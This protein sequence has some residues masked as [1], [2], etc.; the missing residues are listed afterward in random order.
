MGDLERDTR[1]SGGEGRYAITLSRDWEIWGLNGGYM[2]AVA[3]RAAGMEAKIKR[4]VSIAC[5]FLGVP[6]P[7]PVDVEVRAVQ[8]GRRAESIHVLYS[9]DGRPIVQAIVRTAA[10]APGVDHNFL[11]MPE[12]PH[13]S[14]LKSFLDIWT[15]PVEEVPFWNNLDSRIVY[16]ERINDE[17][18]PCPANIVEWYSF[19]PTHTFDDPFVDAARSVIL[20]DTFAWPAGANPHRSQSPREYQGVNL[21]V[22]AWFYEPAPDSEW[23]LCDYDSPIATTGLVAGRGRVWSEDGRLTA[24]GGAQVLCISARERGPQAEKS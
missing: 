4:P 5:H 18:K 13:H 3:L 2:A 8:A 14:E 15:G 22:V 9:Q 11:R 21:D 20:M 17:D 6:R 7:E 23:L 1:L 24:M 10:E 16:P 12:V 19:Q